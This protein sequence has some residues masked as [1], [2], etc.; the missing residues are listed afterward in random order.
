[1]LQSKR[2]FFKTVVRVTVLSEDAPA[3]FD[4]LSELGRMIDSGYEVGQVAVLKRVQLSPR[5]AAQALS[6]YG[7]EPGFFQLK[8]NG[9]DV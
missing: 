5:A 2:K 6:R 4:T 8:G 7:S 3:E 9:E 1:M